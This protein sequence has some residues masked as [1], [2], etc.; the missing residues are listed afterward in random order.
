MLNSKQF[1]VPLARFQ[2]IQ[3]KL[4]DA[5]TEVSTHT[6]GTGSIDNSIAHH[7][8]RL[9][10]V[11]KLVFKQAALRIEINWLQK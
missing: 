1:G 4:A 2:L 6:E 5:N 3:K 9:P 7:S 8:Y 11:F 10:L